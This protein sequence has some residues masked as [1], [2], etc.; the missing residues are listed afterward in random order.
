MK[1]NPVLNVLKS[2]YRISSNMS[3]KSH[4]KG[5]IIVISGPSGVGKSTI[6][7][8]VI[9][10]FADKLFLSVSATTRPMK[11]DEQNGV[12]YHFLSRDEFEKQLKAGNFIEYAEVFG[13]LYGTPKD[14][15]QQSINSGKNVLL[16]IDVQGGLQVKKQFPQAA[17]VFIMPPENKELQ[18]RITGRGRDDEKDI[19]K[20][21]AGADAEIAIGKNYDYKVVN[22][23]LELAIEET[24]QI[25]NKV[26]GEQK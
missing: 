5:A 25:I 15:L 23:K 22:D 1:S 17:L 19:K 13:N 9:T 6:C 8:Q 24:V 2:K 4:A 10:R 26:I 14:K 18:N 11:K 7:K 16:E 12:D 3:N 20:R 21:L